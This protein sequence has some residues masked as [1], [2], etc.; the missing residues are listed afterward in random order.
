MSQIAASMQEEFQ[1]EISLYIEVLKA[2]TRALERY[3]PFNIGI[4]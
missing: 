2:S 4:L 1:K 3:E